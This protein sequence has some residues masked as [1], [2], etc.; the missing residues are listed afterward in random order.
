MIGPSK[1]KYT[2]KEMKKDAL[3]EKYFYVKEFIREKQKQI[4]TIAG[5]VIAIVVVAILLI[6]R[7]S[8]LNEQASAEY[9]KIISIYNNGAYQQ[10]IDGI[11]Q[12]N[13]KGLKYIVSEYGSTE[14]GEDAK[15]LLANSYLNLGQYDEALKYYDDYSGSNKLLKSAAYAGVATCYEAKKEFEKAGEYYF[16]A[17]NVMKSENITPLYLLSAVRC[18][19]LTDKKDQAKKILTQLKKD[20]P[21]STQARDYERYIAEYQSN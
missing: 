16:K 14:V 8:S 6:N 20:F 9:G 13:I 11:P 2:K 19:G 10:A 21:N 4:L 18:Y 17:A 1:R 12:K 3:V 7:S 15:I 5:V